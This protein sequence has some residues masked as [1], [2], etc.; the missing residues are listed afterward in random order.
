[1]GLCNGCN[2]ESGF[3]LSCDY[4]NCDK[5]YHPRCMSE[6]KLIQEFEVMAASTMMTKLKIQPDCTKNVDGS[7][8]K[9]LCKYLYEDRVCTLCP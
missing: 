8:E 9:D 3:V 6:A 5:K 7:P 2:K 1:M 4:I